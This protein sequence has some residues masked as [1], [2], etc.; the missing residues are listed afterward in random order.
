M[1]LKCVMLRLDFAFWNN[2]PYRSMANNSAVYL[3]KPNGIDF[4]KEFT[5]LAASGTGER[6]IF[7]REGDF[8]KNLS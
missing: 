4:M 7:N 6:G 1:T 5:A 2:H 3:E 8:L